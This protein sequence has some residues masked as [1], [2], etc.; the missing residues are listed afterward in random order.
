MKTKMNLSIILTV[1]IMAV[2]SVG[3]AFDAVSYEQ[4]DALFCEGKYKEAAAAFEAL[5]D[6]KDAPER[7]VAA[8]EMWKEEQYQ[9]G[10]RRMAEGN[11]DGARSAFYNVGDYKDAMELSEEAKT[12]RSLAT[13][14]LELLKY[15]E[16]AVRNF[17][18]SIP[19]QLHFIACINPVIDPVTG[20]N[21]KGGF[22]FETARHNPVSAQEVYNWCGQITNTRLIR[23]T[24]PDTATFALIITFTYERPETFRFSDG[25]TVLQYNGSTKAELYNMITGKSI[26]TAAKKTEA[27]YAN[28]RVYVSMLDAAK[29]KQLYARPCDTLEASDF[30]GFEVFVNAK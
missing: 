4:A 8:E 20:E 16:Q 1:V 26:Y 13:E 27:T 9:T 17:T 19:D 23:T 30:K 7:T 3:Y 24:N 6:Y 21:S 10:V 12:L 5:G 18:P 28:E 25:S 2:L 14:L 29:G 15:D 22:R 11:Y